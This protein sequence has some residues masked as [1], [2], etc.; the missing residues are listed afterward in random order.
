MKRMGIWAMAF[1]LSLTLVA[2][3]STDIPTQEPGTA[4]EQQTEVKPEETT[5]E[6]VA[7]ETKEVLPDSTALAAAQVADTWQEIGQTPEDQ[8]ENGVPVGKIGRKLLAVSICPCLA[9]EHA[10]WDLARWG[11][12]GYDGEPIHSELLAF[13]TYLTEHY[14]E[15]TQ[16]Y[17]ELLD[18]TVWLLD[19]DGTDAY[20]Q[21]IAIDADSARQ[22]V[23][24]KQEGNAVD[25]SEGTKALEG[26]VA[27][28][29]AVA[30][31]DPEG[32]QAEVEAHRLAI[33]D[34][35]NVLFTRVCSLKSGRYMKNCFFRRDG[36]PDTEVRIQTACYYMN[37]LAETEIP[38]ES[39]AEE[40][41]PVM[42]P[43]LKMVLDQIDLSEYG[44]E[45]YG[46]GYNEALLR[47]YMALCWEKKDLFAWDDPIFTSGEHDSF[48]VATRGIQNLLKEMEL[49][50][51]LKQCMNSMPAWKFTELT[52]YTS[53]LTGTTPE[54][55]TVTVKMS[56]VFVLV[57]GF[58]TS[59]QEKLQTLSNAG[60]NNEQIPEEIR[61]EFV[62]QL[63]EFVFGNEGAS[64]EVAGWKNGTAEWTWSQQES[65]VVALEI[66]FT[67]DGVNNTGP[68]VTRRFERTADGEIRWL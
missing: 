20:L 58:T 32:Y 40:K 46:V 37:G 14:G 47:Y 25:V 59:Y 4:T 9:Q 31:N 3:D 34:T 44:A 24:L 35:A 51:E 54:N 45:E 38:L 19:S 65:G 2:C 67:P 15:L 57:D 18:G 7:A 21:I 66:V 8:M 56:L 68:Q 10:Q 29:C 11:Y 23:L 26:Y 28:L 64:I 50:P 53:I 60:K 62:D 61:K 5:V 49:N 41:V 42:T 63:L 22:L 17:G 13:Q 48:G 1:L 12:D 43:E 27:A 39:I 36:D 30:R 6:A 52:I 33:P 16:S 55:K